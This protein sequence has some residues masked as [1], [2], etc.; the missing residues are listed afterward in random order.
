[1]NGIYADKT[2]T[3]SVE[4]IQ[5]TVERIMVSVGQFEVAKRYILYRAEH[6]R[7][8]GEKRLEELQ[9][10]EKNMLYVE[11]SDGRKELF[12]IKRV[13]KSRKPNRKRLRRYRHN[14]DSE[15]IKTKRIRRNQNRRNFERI[16][17]G[18]KIIHRT[19]P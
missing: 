6:E 17:Y 9:M 16:S 13:E 5:D 8:R 18:W 14:V 11:T 12:D 7:I 19:R 3:P 10:L 2:E 15:R 1:M 4:E